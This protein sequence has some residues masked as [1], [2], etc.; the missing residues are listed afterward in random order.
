MENKGRLGV[1]DVWQ[2]PP[3]ELVISH[4]QEAGGQI[5]KETMGKRMCVCIS[6]HSLKS[7]V[8]NYINTGNSLVVQWLGLHSSTAG[9]TGSITGHI[10]KTPQA[11]QHSQKQTKKPKI[12][13][14]K[15]K[16]SKHQPYPNI[17]KLRELVM[18]REAWHAPVHGVAKN[19]TR[20]CGWTELNWTETY[21]HT[22][23]SLFSETPGQNSTPQPLSMDNPVRFWYG[24]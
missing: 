15:K 17:Y 22:T 12:Q 14:K 5:Q 13:K 8:K 2:L 24:E 16:K 3:G 11:T 20:L 10:T 1:R 4:E 18:D 19:W 6:K 21:T 23:L 9:D 7:T